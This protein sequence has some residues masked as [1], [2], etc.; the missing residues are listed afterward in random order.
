MSRP[1]RRMVPLLSPSK[2]RRELLR[3]TR[4]DQGQR[5]LP[6]LRN[7]VRTMRPAWVERK[8]Q[9]LVV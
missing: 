1:D 3:H 9:E 2:A 8:V 6:H 4:E 7:K 5:L